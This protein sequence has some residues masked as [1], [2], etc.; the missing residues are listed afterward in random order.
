MNFPRSLFVPTLHNKYPD[1]SFAVSGVSDD[2]FPE[3]ECLKKN[4]YY[5]TYEATNSSLLS[6]R[7]V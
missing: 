6:L 7:R 5:D 2:A 3:G 1:E 4:H